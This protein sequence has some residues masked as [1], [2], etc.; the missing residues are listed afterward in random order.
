[1]LN[2]ALNSWAWWEH[3][4]L[5][6]RARFLTAQQSGQEALG[7]WLLHLKCALS[8]Y[9]DTTQNKQGHGEW[10]GTEVE[11]NVWIPATAYSG[12]T[13]DGLPSKWKTDA[14][15]VDTLESPSKVR[16]CPCLYN[17]Q[18]SVWAAG[19]QP[20]FNKCSTLIR[21]SCLR[22]LLFHPAKPSNTCSQ[23]TI[24]FSS[25]KSAISYH[26]WAPQPLQ[27]PIPQP[28][29]TATTR[30]ATSSTSSTGCC[31]RHHCQA[32]SKL[33]ILRINPMT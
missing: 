18:I 32:Q 20:L 2:T 24:F 22:L 6:K 23:K 5:H 17:S 28:P 16:G 10:G 27:H 30:A 8:R 21:R 7:G 12:S 4:E 14:L 19:L 31:W 25:L 11:G 15:I 9:L 33:C 3:Q 13:G 29:M 26:P 1:M